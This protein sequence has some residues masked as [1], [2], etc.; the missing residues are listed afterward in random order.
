MDQELLTEQ[1]H[2]F[3]L[4]Q[5]FGSSEDVF[6]EFE[7]NLFRF[8]TTGKSPKSKLVCNVI[9]KLIDSYNSSTTDKPS[10]KY[11]FSIYNWRTDTTIEKTFLPKQ[12][13]SHNTFKAALLGHIP[14]GSFLG[15]KSDFSEYFM[16][17]VT[18][19]QHNK[20]IKERPAG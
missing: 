13:T 10:F 4:S 11:V 9:P 16:S 7:G 20:N 15:N 19:L 8:I 3:A 5:S 6:Y 12:L 14:G 2:T 1:A 17:E 18:K